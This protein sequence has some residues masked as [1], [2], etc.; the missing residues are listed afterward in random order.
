MEVRA[1]AA[2]RGWQWIV[3]GYR[4]FRLNALTWAAI[5]IA[6]ALLWMASL[7]I[8]V[9]GPLL[10]NLLSPVFFAGLM[11]GC[12]ALERGEKLEVLHLFA[13]FKQQAAQLVTVG[14]VYLVGTILVFGLVFYLADGL[15]LPSLLS[16]S[17]TD[18][19][20][21]REATRRLVPA[22]A[23]GAA[24]YLPLLM[25]IWFAPL[26]VVFEGLR[27][28]DAMRISF[29]ACLMNTLPFL[30]YGAAILALWL[31]LSLPAVLG[32]AGAVLVIAL[33]VASIPVLFCSIYTSYK[34]IF[35]RN[36][37]APGP[38][39]SSNGTT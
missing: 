39:N 23:I 13:G 7:V 34:D 24:A 19:E 8:P 38:T 12:R 2:R 15:K 32:A 11:I 31:A 16:K 37:S 14:G 6:L 5:T 33:L 27:P 36:L 9:L 21:M 4:L 26:L 3:E 1:V 25:L 18:P 10:F 22:L 28:V 29:F 35:V 20:A 17:G 30:V